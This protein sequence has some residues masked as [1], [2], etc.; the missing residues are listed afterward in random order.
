MKDYAKL[1]HDEMA[2]TM[3]CLDKQILATPTGS[4][5]E[6]LTEANIHFMA[7]QDALRKANKL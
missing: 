1:I 4:K 3:N 7:A 2:L 5:R 6:L